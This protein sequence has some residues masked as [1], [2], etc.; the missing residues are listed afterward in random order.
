MADLFTWCATNSTSGE[1]NAS[2]LRAQFGDGYAQSS[3][4]G[5]NPNRRSWNVTFT[6]ISSRTT[7]I[8]QFLDSHVGQSFLWDSPIYGE[9]LFY[10]DTYALSPNGNGV[11]TIS[12]T[13]EQT[14][15]P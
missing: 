12:A 10:C 1:S 9:A 15:Q 4:D 8:V 6:G 14:Y 7:E 5:I 13:F 11:W 2:V 3:A